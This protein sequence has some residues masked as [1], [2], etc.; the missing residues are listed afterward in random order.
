[1]AHP[2]DGHG[3]LRHRDDLQ[4][5]RA[6]AVL[7]VVLAHA[8]VRAFKGGFIGVDVFFVLSGYLITGLLLTQAAKTGRISL[9]E[10]YRRRA[11]RILPAAVL[12]LVVTD[13]AAWQLLNLIRA[14]QAV[15]DSLWASVF[16]A[17]IHFAAENSD[18][19]A[20]NRPV[21]PLQHFWTLSVEEQFY[22]AWPIVL[23]L[24]LFGTL[25]LR[26]RPS[27]GGISKAGLYRAFVFIFVAGEVSLAWSIHATDTTPASA[28]FSTF[29]RAWELA[30]GAALAIAAP[31]LRSLPP[32]LQ[33]FLSAAGLVCI[34]AAGVLFSAGT[35][36]PGY[37]AILPTMGAA[38]VIGAG[39][40]T[41]RPDL[42]VLRLLSLAPFR[43]VGDRSY[44]LYLWHWPVLILAAQYEGH[45][46]GLGKNLLLVG[47][48]FLLSMVSY[49]TFED[50][51][52]RMRFR[53]PA[54]GLLLWPASLAVVLL[55]ALPIIHTI[56]S[57]AA[58]IARFSANLKVPPLSDPGSAGLSEEN[59]LPAVI[60]AARAA[61]AGDPIP[62]PLVPSV[63][64]IESDGYSLPNG[65]A[66]GP[67][68]TSSRV[69]PLGDLSS[70]RTLAVIGD[71]HARMWLPT[72][73]RMAQLDHWRVLP[74]IKEGCAPKG[75]LTRSLFHCNVW[76]QW[77]VA[78]VHALRPTVSLVMGK[79]SEAY[80]AGAAARG[81][82]AAVTAFS[83]VS[84]HVVVVSD[85][86]VAPENSV[87]CLL[88]RGATMTTCSPIAPA[89]T[90]NADRAVAQA[91][92]RAGGGFMGVGGWFCA[93]PYPNYPILC[94]LVINRTITLRDFNHVSKT[95][96]LE[97]TNEFR[98]SFRRALATS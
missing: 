2:E 43:Y 92:A 36:F 53:R 6:V 30:L 12:T 25:A 29:A 52:R 48:A 34:L 4:G 66:A 64:T 38:L 10:F 26:S 58:S 32:L 86:V 70:P 40:P 28:Y 60:A 90:I 11:R 94:P 9:A 39:I 88:T 71:S 75:W 73:L 51:I 72:I 56:D 47:G 31:R 74:L 46:L 37:A 97:L 41:T 21:S 55:F 96:A 42:S 1:M 62:W 19:F 7:L 59:P 17:N 85:P 3:A 49:A 24:V 63:T 69:C 79:W 5:L 67:T 16:A 68:D 57:Q 82:T 83:R 27:L 22:V 54:Y 13:I 23:A 44:A 89:N 15:L 33:T 77:A 65:C 35:A 93:H 98:A 18:Y 84:R 50:P 87:D 8:G 76:F 14:K 95:Y 81:V 20:R 61:E 45:D 91:V 80:P 78:K